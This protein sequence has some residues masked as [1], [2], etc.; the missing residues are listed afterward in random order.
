MKQ[1]IYL[2]GF[3]HKINII[4]L[5]DEHIAFS[6]R[7]YQTKEFIKIFDVS[8][9]TIYNWFNAWEELNLVGLYD[10]KGR[11]RKPKF[12]SEQKERGRD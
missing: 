9:V 4:T 11:G 12:N 5:E 6:S 10:R 3:M 7:G 2:N 8:I 1:L